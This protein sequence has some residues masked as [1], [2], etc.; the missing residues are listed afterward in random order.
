MASTVNRMKTLDPR[1]M[2]P[3]D[4]KFVIDPQNPPPPSDQIYMSKN[5]LN[6]RLRI[7]FPSSPPK[8]DSRVDQ[9]T[10]KII[11]PDGYGGSRK[12]RKRIMNRRKQYKRKSSYKSTSRRIR[13]NRK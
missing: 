5:E 11:V 9:V 1:N 10:G 8:C 6:N 7:T 4:P 13:N 12:T 3:Y 2:V